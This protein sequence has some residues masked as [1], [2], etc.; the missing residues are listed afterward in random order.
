M[1]MARPCRPASEAESVLAAAAVLN[2]RSARSAAIVIAERVVAE[3]LIETDP[4]L[5][6]FERAMLA[7]HRQIEPS[8]FADLACDPACNLA[9]MLMAERTAAFEARG[10]QQI[11][12]EAWATETIAI[13]RV[14]TERL[15]RRYRNIFSKAANKDVF[16]QS[17]GAAQGSSL[18]RKDCH[19]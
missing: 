4:A 14:L 11:G 10:C 8:P 2:K 18:T 9:A 13:S 12:P 19:K 15:A 1:A 5:E 6:P 16:G 7:L 3:L 17:G